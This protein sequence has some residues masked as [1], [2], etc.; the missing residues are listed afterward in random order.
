EGCLKDEALFKKV[1]GVRT[2]ANEEFGVNSTPTFF[3]N[4]KALVGPPSLEE[5][6]AII[7]PL[8]AEE[9]A[10]TTK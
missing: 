1:V 8:R 2:R 10:K 3:I 4:G 7:A 6:D 5:F 9:K